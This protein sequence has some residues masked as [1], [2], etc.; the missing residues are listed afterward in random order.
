MNLF[1]TTPFDIDTTLA[2][3]PDEDFDFLEQI[4]FAR[5]NRLDLKAMRS[6]E[7]ASG[8]RVTV[9]R[10]PL[11]PTL[12]M[13]YRYNFSKTSSRYT[14]GSGNT[15][16]Y[17]WS[18]SSSWSIFDRYQTYANISSAK[19]NRRIA[20][21]NRQQVELDAVREIRGY[22]NQLREAR[23]RLAVASENVLRAEEDLRLAIE[24]FRVGAGTILDRIT[25]ESDLT[26]TRSEVVTA[27]VDYLVAKANLFRAT[28]R[29]LSEL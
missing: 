10:G 8:D 24:K 26:T 16:N 18:I 15:A 9:A 11:F 29:P 21:Y 1:V 17:G 19:A 2:T 4:E 3:I 27:I 6:V 20:E 22:L 12:D 25:A 23:E 13:S 5:K 7:E 14:F 28:G